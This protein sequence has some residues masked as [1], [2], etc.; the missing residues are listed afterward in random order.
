MNPSNKQQQ[1][2]KLTCP[3][4][5]SSAAGELVA[6][7]TDLGERP[8]SWGAGRGG[9]AAVEGVSCEADL[10]RFTTGLFR[11]AMLAARREWRSSGVGEGNGGLQN[12]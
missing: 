2:K 8:C 6:S 3:E 12:P 11:E 5:A 9:F 4:P 10:R 1:S 7:T